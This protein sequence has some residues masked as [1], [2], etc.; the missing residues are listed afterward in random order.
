MRELDL[1]VKFLHCL[2]K[3]EY[4]E[5]AL[6]D[7]LMLMDH[8]VKFS[9]TDDKDQLARL[10]NDLIPLIEFKLKMLG[11]E[12]NSLPH[13]SSQNLFAGIGTM[14][15]S[16]PMICLT[17]VAPGRLISQHRFLFGS[18]GLVLRNLWVARNN[19]E[20]IIYAGHGSPASKILFNCLATM[21]IMGL[22][23]SQDGLLVFDTRTHK[24][25]LPLLS[26]FE[27]RDN[28]SEAEWRIAGSTGYFGGKRN[29]GERL[30]LQLE[31]IEYIFTPN[32]ILKDE[33]QVVVDELAVVQ[34][35]KRVP[36]VIV[37][38]DAIPE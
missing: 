16:V 3:Y 9:V 26:Y 13:D 35:C 32:A 11:L 19:A 17:E 20:R 36:Q 23:V 5:S 15:G 6:R 24:A 8:D 34:S 21:H 14:Q 38:P 28:V 27:S 25:A 10:L 7:G 33:I 2:P 37:F 30:P 31:E 22:H 18:F 29:T 4:L 1:S 12:L